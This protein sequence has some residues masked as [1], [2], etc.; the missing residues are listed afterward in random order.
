MNDRQ[1]EILRFGREYLDACA[2][3]EQRD[4]GEE[5]VIAPDDD[6][7][8]KK[9]PQPLSAIPM[10]GRMFLRR[11]VLEMTRAAAESAIDA[12]GPDYRLLLIDAYRPPHVQRICFSLVSNYFKFFG[13]RMDSE[14]DLAAFVN[15]FSADPRYGGH[16]C[17]AAVDASLWDIRNN[18][19]ADFGGDS[20]K[21]IFVDSKGDAADGGPHTDEMRKK[22]ADCFTRHG[23]KKTPCEWWHFSYGDCE[24]AQLGGHPATLYSAVPWSLDMLFG[25]AVR[26]RLA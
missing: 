12:F 5:L 21:T 13:P 23:F 4:N 24:W 20:F 19:R 22:F 18:R 26:P 15:S 3:I 6:R 2:R 25:D 16:P 9:Q 14:D 17:G 1:K 7:L 11:T 10:A 8:W